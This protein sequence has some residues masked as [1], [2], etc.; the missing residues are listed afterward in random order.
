MTPSNSTAGRARVSS[1]RICKTAT[2]ENWCNDKVAAAPAASA[3]PA[4]WITRRSQ[5]LHT[6]KMLSL[7]IISTTDL[8]SIPF[9]ARLRLKSAK[10]SEVPKR[11][12]ERTDPFWIQDRFVGNIAKKPRIT[13]Y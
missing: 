10:R 3:A 5:V 2:P 8:A 6:G 12:N 1:H 9:Q 7:P 4:A 13:I 11:M